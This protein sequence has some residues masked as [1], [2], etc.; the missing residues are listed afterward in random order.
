MF[1]FVLFYRLVWNREA[2]PGIALLHGWGRPTTII[3]TK[4][5]RSNFRQTLFENSG[6]GAYSSFR[7]QSEAS[8]LRIGISGFSFS[9][10]SFDSTMMTDTSIGIRLRMPSSDIFFGPAV[11]YL[12]AG[13][14]LD[15]AWKNQAWYAGIEG[16]YVY[17][18]VGE[19]GIGMSLRLKYLPIGKEWGRRL[20]EREDSRYSSGY[21]RDW[22]KY[23]TDVEYKTVI[24]ADLGLTISF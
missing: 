10:N 17:Y 18:F 8:Y 3:W 22:S 9:K 13:E 15:R 23:A 24:G 14:D 16:N 1:L 11:S 7:I 19:D 6:F 4:L 12:L 20:N 2:R 21:Y 5:E